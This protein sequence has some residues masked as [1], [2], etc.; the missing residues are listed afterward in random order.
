MQMSGPI[1]QTLDRILRERIV[2]LADGNPGAARV[3]IEATSGLLAR[4][5]AHAF[6]QT[7]LKHNL[8]GSRIWIGYKYACREDLSAFLSRVAAE[9]SELFAY[10]DRIQRG[11][12]P[13]Q[14]S[15][16]RL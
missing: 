7:C 1:D 9:D 10:V 12:A 4:D 6:L 13:A 8:R 11:E 2:S 3:L 15:A 5:R 16:R 14:R